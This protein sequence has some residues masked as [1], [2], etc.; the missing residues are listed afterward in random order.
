MSNYSDFVTPPKVR[1]VAASAQ[2]GSL[3]PNIDTTDV[4]SVSGVNGAVTFE[5]PSGTKNDG[6]RLVIRIEDDGTPRTLSWT[7]TTSGYRSAGAELPTT[8]TATKVT[9]V[10]CMY[11]NTETFWDVVAVTTE[12]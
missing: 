7:A 1:T 5:I 10:G 2:S 3:T 11:N 8:T 6:Q 4:F 9:Y 12:D